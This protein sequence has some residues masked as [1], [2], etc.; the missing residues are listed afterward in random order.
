[1]TF[2]HAYNFV[3][4]YRLDG[5]HFGDGRPAG[6]DTLLDPE[7]E[8]AYF[9]GHLD[10]EMTVVTA[11]LCAETRARDPDGHRH[12]QLRSRSGHPGGPA[13]PEDIEIPVTAV[14]GMLRSAFE[15]VTASR[16][17]VF[18]DHQHPG[19]YRPPPHEGMRLVPAR[20]I[21]AGGELA[22]DLMLGNHAHVAAGAPDPRYAASL[23]DPADEHQAPYLF[24]P[25]GLDRLRAVPHGARVTARMQLI[26]HFGRGTYRYWLV[27]H[28]D[29]QRCVR[30]SPDGRHRWTG[31][32]LEADGFVCRTNSVP[33][34]PT[35]AG[36]HDERLFF[37]RHPV[38][39]LP[40][41]PA[42]RE[43]YRK[44]V[45]SY[46]EQRQ[47]AAHPAR[48]SRVVTASQSGGLRPGDLVYATIE[49]GR[50]LAL[51]P[52][53][54]GR[55]QYQLGPASLLDEGLRPATTLDQ[56]S[57]A[58]RVFGAP[59][60]RGHLTISPVEPAGVYLGTGPRLLAELAAP[61]PASARFYVSSDNRGTPL[62]ADP[63]P[64]RS[65]LYGPRQ[66]LRGRKV[67]PHHRSEEKQAG[68]P[69][70]ALSRQRTPRNVTV[71]SWVAP[72]SS[73]RFRIDFTNLTAFQLGAL[74]WLLTP[75]ELAYPDNRDAAVEGYHRLGYGKPLGLGS[76][77]LAL[78]HGTSRLVTTGLLREAYRS[79]TGVRGTVGIPL[80]DGLPESF[81]ARLVAQ[82]GVENIQQIPFVAALRRA[83]SGYPDGARVGYPSAPRAGSAGPVVSW[84]TTNERVRADG[85][86]I[87]PGHGR[88]L[89][90]LWD[91]SPA[92]LPEY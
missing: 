2:H 79:L 56:F 63:P 91:G 90:P 77:R 17:G 28:L 61:K 43:S 51:Q 11:L 67:Y 13:A 21:E 76:V 32:E 15:A 26:Q 59:G 71:H 87:R 8:T 5:N 38:P 29:G 75:A 73:F 74:A 85:A 24:T 66:G 72:G 55:R 64:M 86:R 47:H 68:L 25:G 52:T 54:I 40:I 9:H 4:A 58:D 82:V 14:K 49:S 35:V 36:K 50:I 69:P 60:Y 42:A 3:P 78:D 84:F 83:A 27:T 20:I 57:P 88:T 37:A 53:V 39:P 18:G 89:P 12:L 46:L 30:R 70:Q 45:A 80:P 81:T 7:R 31:T 16:F 19:S 6:H 33:G 44:V 22:A 65:E 41:S 23:P 62:P 48:P 92:P 1:V 34:E 10:V